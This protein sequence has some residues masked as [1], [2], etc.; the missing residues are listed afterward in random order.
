M[1][2]EIF[3]LLYLEMMLCQGIS[4]VFEFDCCA[5]GFEFNL[6]DLL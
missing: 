3:G 6:T 4:P 5:K 1:L 2:V